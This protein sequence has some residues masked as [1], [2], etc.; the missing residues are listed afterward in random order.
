MTDLNLV[1]NWKPTANK[2]TIYEQNH[3]V[4]ERLAEIWGDNKADYFVNPS[5]M[6]K[7]SHE[8]NKAEDYVEKK[9]SNPK[10]RGSR[11][12]LYAYTI[13]DNL[14]EDANNKFKLYSLEKDL[15]VNTCIYKFK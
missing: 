11:T 12:G 8:L 9:L 10:N 1:A 6:V 4:R 15:S 14:R 7:S 13:W 5:R 3:W 2:S